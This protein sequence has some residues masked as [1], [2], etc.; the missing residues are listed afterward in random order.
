MTCPPTA[1]RV[2][3]RQLVVTRADEARRADFLEAVNQE[4]HAILGWTWV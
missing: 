1:L 4:H 3:G 2:Y